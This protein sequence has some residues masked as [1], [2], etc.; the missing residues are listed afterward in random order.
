M[1]ILNSKLVSVLIAAA[2]CGCVENTID[3]GSAGNTDSGSRKIILTSQDAENGELLVKFSEEAVSTVV[4]GMT[5]SESTRTGIQPFDA[6]MTDIQA[7]SLERVFPYVEKSEANTRAFGLDRW[8]IVKFNADI[9][10]DKAA[11]RLADV[12]EVSFVQY[13]GRIMATS[14]EEPV[15]YDQAWSTSADQTDTRAESKFNDP[16]LEKQW[17]Y[18]NTGNEAI[19][20]PIKAGCDINLEA[21]WELCAGD[22]TIVVA[23]VDQGVQYTHEDLAANMWANEKELNGVKGVDDDK[24]GYTDDIYG[25]NFVKGHGGITWN[26]GDDTGHGIHVAG[27]VSA[28]NNNGAGVC[29]VAGGS[30]NNDGVKL[31]SVQVFANG[32]STSTGQ[33]AKAIKY[34]ADNGAD[35]LQCSWGTYMGPTTDEEYL[36]SSSIEADAFKYF[37]NT[38]RPGRPINGGIAIVAAGNEGSACSYPGA[39]P[40]MVCVT[41]LSTDFTPSSFTNFGLPADISAPGGDLNYHEKNSSTGGVLSTLREVNSWYGYM[42]GTS[43][44]CPHVSGVAALGLSYAHKLGKTFQ[45]N[46]FRSLLLGSVNELESYLTGTKNYRPY[47]NLSGVMNM[48]DY[49]GKMGGGMVD[50]YKMLLAV[51]GTPAITVKEG[52]EITISLSKY[53]GDMTAQTYELKVPTAVAEKL[54]LTQTTGEGDKVKITCAKQGAGLVTVT[55]TVGR[56]PMSREVAIICRNKVASNGGWL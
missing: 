50:A 9:S 22:P 44:S 7:I 52:E 24:N 28:V 15:P 55:T 41:A 13:N 17:H 56:T 46:E 37:I 4:Y 54:G 26:E 10:L 30:G 53:Y 34:A 5:R 51:R 25:Y 36:A 27:T 16:R 19:V 35:V 29:G 12:G 2:L 11:R 32:R 49:K 45:P 47:S 43:M 48:E 21:A 18:K 31:M 42:S 20:K 33:T 6:A 1:K 3:E 40:D 38:P 8:Y 23:I 39:Y 14:N